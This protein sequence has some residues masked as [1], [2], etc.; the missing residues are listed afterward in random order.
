MSTECPDEI[1]GRL[2][3]VGQLEESCRPTPYEVF[4]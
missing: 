1:V 3:D 2:P 4:R